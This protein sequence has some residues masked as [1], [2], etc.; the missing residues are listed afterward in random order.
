MGRAGLEVRWSTVTG[1][2][3]HIPRLPS[4]SI[5]LSTPFVFVFEV[6]DRVAVKRLCAFSTQRRD[7]RL[8]ERLEVVY[9]GPQ[10][11][12]PVGGVEGVA[13]LVGAVLEATD[14]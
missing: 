3:R 6:K 13:G 8:L 12:V 4:M 5:L 9:D 7:Y 1:S 10:D 14:R 11:L 2:P